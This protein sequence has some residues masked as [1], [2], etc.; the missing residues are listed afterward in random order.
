[1][2]EDFVNFRARN[3]PLTISF[4]KKCFKIVF[5]F[6]L[7]SRSGLG[8]AISDAI[9]RSSIVWFATQ[10]LQVGLVSVS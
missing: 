6:A 5:F 2:S 1:M 9:A 3:F 4:F 10:S 7:A 8:A